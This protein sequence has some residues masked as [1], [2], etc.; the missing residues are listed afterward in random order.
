MTKNSSLSLSAEPSN[1]KDKILKNMIKV[2]GLSLAVLSSSFFAHAAEAAQKVGYVNTAQVFQELP[3]RE[4]VL[5][6]MQEEFKDRADELKKIEANAK[7]K[8]EKLQRDG[9]L[10]S[11]EEVEALRLEIGQLDNTFKLKA[12]ALDKATQRRE[13]QEKQK[14]FKVIQDAIAKVSEKEGYDLIVDVQAVA[15][16]NPDYDISEKVISSLK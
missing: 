7:T 9:E 8:I 5:Q 6:T 1:L 10:M 2:A 16:A 13:A 14:L 3:Q 4:I 15:F 12:Q 11:P